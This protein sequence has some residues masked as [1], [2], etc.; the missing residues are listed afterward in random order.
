MS[1]CTATEVDVGQ[2][3]FYRYLSPSP[4]PPKRSLQGLI[5]LSN[6]KVKLF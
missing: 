1:F 2:R 5:E 4:K 6:S 3:V